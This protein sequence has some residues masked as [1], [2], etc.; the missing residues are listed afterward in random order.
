M[1]AAR[2]DAAAPPL[3]LAVLNPVDD[4]GYSSNVIAMFTELFEAV[5]VPVDLVQFDA[6]Q[7]IFPTPEERA[8]FDGFI[9]PGSLHGAYE[10]L[11]WIDSLAQQIRELDDARRPI[12]GVCF[13]HQITAQALGGVVEPNSFEC[14]AG[15]IPFTLSPTGARFLKQSPDDRECSLLFHHN[16]IVKTLPPGRGSCWSGSEKNPHHVC[17]YGGLADENG[18]D[19]SSG[20][21]EPPRPHIVTFQAHPE[22]STPTGQHVLRQIIRERDTL[23]YDQQW[24]DE[25]EASIG[26]EGTDWRTMVSRA[27]DLLWPDRRTTSQ[28]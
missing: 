15:A 11:P 24:C 25:K 12:L 10:E 16:D 28:P 5:E 3:R 1:A 20:D 23:T 2:E 14:Q 21:P 7:L 6:K 4:S 22:F 9:V 13:G 19:G 27:I 26:Q 18:W 8:M 17:A